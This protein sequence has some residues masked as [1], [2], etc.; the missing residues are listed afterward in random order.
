M[1]NEKPHK[2]L[3]EV[4]VG[5]P[6]HDPVPIAIGTLIMSQVPEYFSFNFSTI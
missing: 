5:P 4:D 1:I 6:G 3:Y 2:L